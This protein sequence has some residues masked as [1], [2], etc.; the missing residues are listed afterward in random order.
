M[1]QGWSGVA[2]EDSVRG[3]LGVRPR[4][5]VRG[6]HLFSGGD[7][8]RLQGVTY[9]PFGSDGAGDEYGTPERVGDDF[10]AMVAAG[11]NAVRTYTPPPRWLLDLAHARDLRVLV[12]LPWEQHVAFLEGKDRR[13][14]IRERV[15]AGARA[16]AAH[17]ALLGFAIGNEIPA[18]VVRWHGARAVE[19]FLGGLAAAVRDEDPQ[20]LLT[21]V[22]YPSTEYLTLDFV[23]FVGFNVFLETRRSLD[24]YLARLQNLADERPLVLAELGLDSRRNGLDVQAKL[25]SS[26]LRTVYSAG[27]AGAFVFSWTDEWHRGGCAIDDWDFGLVD[28]RRRPKPALDAVGGAFAAD[29]YPAGRRWPAVTVAVCTRNGARTLGRCLQAIAG[30]DYPEVELVVVD[31]GSADGSAAIAEEYGGRVLRT[32]GCGLA[33]ARNVA[34]EAARGEIVAFVDDDA[35]PDRDWLRQLCLAFDGGDVGG[36]GGPNVPP[37]TD[38]AIAA[39][40]ARAPGGPQHVLLSDRDAEHLPGCNMA[41]RRDALA[42]VG[43]FDPQFV[44]AGDD[45]DLCWRLQEHGWRLRFAP[46]AVVWHHRRTSIRAYWR[47]QRGYGRAEA[48]LERKWPERYNLAGHVSWAGRM[49]GATGQAA[50]LH[51]RRRVH[52][53]VWGSAAYQQAVP[54]EDP[55]LAWVVGTPE[56]LLVVAVLAALSALG[57]AWRPLSWTLP[58]LGLSLLP[59]LAGAL[60]GALRAF[61]PRAGDP[62]RPHGARLVVAWLH[63][64]QPVARL[65]G[66]LRH[67]LTPWRRHGPVT[68]A[69]PRPRTARVWSEEWLAGDARLHELSRRLRDAGAVVRHGGAEDRWDLETRAG[70]LGSVRISAVVEEHGRG[71]QLVRLRIRPRVPALACALVAV[72]ALLAAVAALDGAP[73][74]LVAVFAALAASLAAGAGLACATATGCTVR[75]LSGE[76]PA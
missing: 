52:F 64:I 27:C 55:R 68:L 15:A 43:G 67:G 5:E 70:A 33:A 7:K 10:A 12:G 48:L 58:V 23:D 42:A 20:A 38:G 45:V 53:G 60:A 73:Q 63:L 1:G 3:R 54:R 29:A 37:R 16:C 65:A 57:A 51:R 46:A 34:V 39:C 17:P 30:L 4:V 44:T 24:R 50:R 8:L 11:V 49:Y 31:D 75:A 13:R 32:G 36:A 62:A 18:G 56:W 47:Q 69:L 21:Y 35:Y 9:G 6:P 61:P 28:R 25:V 59:P 2:A 72:S 74:P 40:V 26:Q 22:N 76:E 71:R 66:R 14:S 19:R 41:F